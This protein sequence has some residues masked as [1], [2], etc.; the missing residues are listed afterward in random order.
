MIL[1]P[2]VLFLLGLPDKPPAIMAHDI[3]TAGLAV[4]TLPEQACFGA[5]FEMA[6]A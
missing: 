3:S 5:A 2:I 6:E 4:T 1:V